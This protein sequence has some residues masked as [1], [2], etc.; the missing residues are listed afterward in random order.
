VARVDID[1][2]RVLERY[3]GQGLHQITDAGQSFGMPAGPL[4]TTTVT[5][6]DGPFFPRRGSL[7]RALDERRKKR[8]RASAVHQN[9][10]GRSE[11]D[12]A[13]EECK[14]SNPEQASP[15]DGE[16]EEQPETISPHQYGG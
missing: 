14:G 6:P 11:D 9:E 2:G 13:R 4:T 15:R 7:D 10:S 8:G 12:K 1:T 5:Y 3:E 16:Q